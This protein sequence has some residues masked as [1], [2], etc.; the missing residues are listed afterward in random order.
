M[1]TPDGHSRRI[2]RRALGWMAAAG[3]VG[4]GTIPTRVEAQIVVSANDAKV[5]LVDG[6]QVVG[7]NPPPDTVTIWDF[8]VTPP[9]T[10]AAITV[11]TSLVGPP[12]SVAITPNR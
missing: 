2:V 9:R 12:S 5:T 8:D 10:V 7:R 1:H 4:V 6:V 11:P 3:V